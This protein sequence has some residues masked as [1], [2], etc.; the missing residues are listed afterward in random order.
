LQSLF[1]SVADECNQTFQSTC[2][3][4]HVQWSAN[5]IRLNNAALNKSVPEDAAG[6]ALLEA[7]AFRAPMKCCVDVDDDASISHLKTVILCCQQRK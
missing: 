7:N 5:V 3:Q 1:V 4:K 6:V 2:K